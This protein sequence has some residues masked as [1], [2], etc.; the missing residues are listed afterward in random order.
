MAPD[1]PHELREWI[2]GV[3]LPV[4][5]FLST[6]LY[7]RSKDKADDEQ[8]NTDRVAIIIKSLG[9]ANEPERYLA[10]GYVKYLAKHQEAPSELVELLLTDASNAKTPAESADAV[11]ALRALA[12]QGEQQNN[13][14]TKD[15]N[16]LPVRVY[17]HIQKEQDRATAAEIQ[18][19]L[20]TLGYAVPGIE[21]VGVN[22]RTSQVRYANS[23]DA[24]LAK[25]LADQLDK[26]YTGLNVQTQSIGAY[27]ASQNIAVP[28]RVLELWLVSNPDIGS[29]TPSGL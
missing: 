28:L 1:K 13:A 6:F 21:L 25:T 24:G 26:K 17:I 8:R 14:I 18:R 19:W 23:A 7:T 2:V 22:L 15:V 9:S 27:A 4:A 3:A 5:I 29:S 12:S 11:S 10:R 16:N 20:A